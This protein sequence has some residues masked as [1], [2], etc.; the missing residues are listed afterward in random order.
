MDCHLSGAEG[1]WTYVWGWYV[2]PRYS[3]THLKM[4]YGFQNQSP[5]VGL[6]LISFRS[7]PWW[8]GLIYSPQAQSLYN[9]VFSSW[10]EGPFTSGKSF[11]LLDF[12]KH[13]TAIWNSPTF[14]KSLV[15]AL[16][17]GPKEDSIVMQGTLWGVP[18]ESGVLVCCNVLFGRF[19]IGARVW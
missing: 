5:W 14:R 15:W 6:N 4:Q 16:E 13:Q 8:N 19:T 7:C 11:Q 18:R 9:L 17:C 1:T 12:L 3:W 10:W 2:S